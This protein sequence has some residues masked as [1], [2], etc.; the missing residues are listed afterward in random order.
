MQMFK[1]LILQLEAM[2]P[3]T[4]I[5][6][7]MALDVRRTKRMMLRRTMMKV[8]TVKTISKTVIPVLLRKQVAITHVQVAVVTMTI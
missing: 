5:L 7:V 4:L 3:I 2:I 1:K 8:T 6:M